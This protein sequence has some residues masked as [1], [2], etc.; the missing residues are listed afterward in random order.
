MPGPESQRLALFLDGDMASD[1]LVVGAWLNGAR[2]LA[3]SRMND[4]D[5]PAC[6]LP[7]N[8]LTA[9]EREHGASPFC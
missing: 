7:T 4:A 2:V 6:L 5:N 9:L 1:P 8:H 3:L